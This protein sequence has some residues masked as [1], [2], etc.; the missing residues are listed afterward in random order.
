VTDGRRDF[1]VMEALRSASGL[2]PQTWCEDAGVFWIRY[3]L[4]RFY[5]VEPTQS[6]L[7]GFKR[8]LEE[9]QRMQSLKGAA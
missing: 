6:E 8:A 3:G 2:H 4:I 5:G 9:H 1:N 7:A